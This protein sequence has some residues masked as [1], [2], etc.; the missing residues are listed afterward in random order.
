MTNLRGSE[1]S[2]SLRR[3][4]S[5]VSTQPLLSPS[6]SST[7]SG[8]VLVGGD[9]G[10]SGIGPNCRVIQRGGRNN[11]ITSGFSNGRSSGAEYNNGVVTSAPPHKRSMNNLD[12]KGNGTSG[13]KGMMGKKTL[14]PRYFLLFLKMV[15]N[16]CC[17]FICGVTPFLFYI[18]SSNLFNS[19]QLASN[20]TSLQFLW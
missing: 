8:V 1:S 2:S 7:S 15:R 4:A 11:T 20:Q 17:S 12:L 10:S 13:R 16:L 6:G 19:T 9:Y 3:V 18:R 14:Y 5:P